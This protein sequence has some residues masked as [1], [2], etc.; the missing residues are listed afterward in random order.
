MSLQEFV[1]LTGYSDQRRKILSGFLDLRRE[2]KR[3]G[4]HGAQWIDGSFLEH[5]YRRGRAPADLD[6]VTWVTAPD[7]TSMGWLE[8]A[9]KDLPVGNDAKKTYLCDVYFDIANADGFVE[10]SGAAYW[11]GLFGHTRSKE[12][13]GF[14]QISLEEDEDAILIGGSDEDQE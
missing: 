1:D 14:I 4:L 12:W 11:I 7:L 2:L 13:K 9:L 5:E 10:P 3:R 6:V 8:E